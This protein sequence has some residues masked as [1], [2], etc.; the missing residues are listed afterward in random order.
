ME[1]S[2]LYS[3]TAPREVERRRAIRVSLPFPAVVRGIDTSGMR[4]TRRTVL[5][6]L[7]AC[8]LYMRLDCAV[9]VGSRLFVIVRLSLERSAESAPGPG[10]AL[11]GDVVRVEPQPDGTYGVAL[12]FYRHRFLY[13]AENT[14]SAMYVQTHI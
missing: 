1:A 5:G 9:A 8:G 2:E 12:Q 4:F 13:E 3:A 6:N 10:V 7:S 14:F 11:Y